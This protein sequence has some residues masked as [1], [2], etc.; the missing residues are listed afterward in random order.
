MMKYDVTMSKNS[1]SQ[2][3]LSQLHPGK[4]FHQLAHSTVSG[5]SDDTQVEGSGAVSTLLKLNKFL[6]QAAPYLGKTS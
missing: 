4:G 2:A 3:P 5:K 1:Q 6:L